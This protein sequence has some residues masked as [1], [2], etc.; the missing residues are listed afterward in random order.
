MVGSR[1]QVPKRKVLR[2]AKYNPVQDRG[3]VF[4]KQ[5]SAAT[6]STAIVVVSIRLCRDGRSW[7]DHISGVESGHEPPAKNEP[8]FCPVMGWLVYTAFVDAY[9]VQRRD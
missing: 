7:E 9:R 8:R 1:M 6:P 5:R 2:G 4:E 3:E